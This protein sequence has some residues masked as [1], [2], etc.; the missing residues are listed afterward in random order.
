MESTIQIVVPCSEVKSKMTEGFQINAENTAILNNL[1]PEDKFI[2]QDFLHDG[3]Q[4]E[5]FSY[6]PLKQCYMFK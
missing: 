6:N 2:Y 4:N 5:F 3:L 1:D